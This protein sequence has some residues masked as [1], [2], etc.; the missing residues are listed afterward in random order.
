MPNRS[1]R[2]L[3]ILSLILLSLFAFPPRLCAHEEIA[4]LSIQK[5]GFFKFRRSIFKQRGFGF[6]KHA[7]SPPP[8]LYV[9]PQVASLQSNDRIAIAGDS[10]TYLGFQPGGWVSLWQQYVQTYYP[11]MNLQF[12]DY[13]VPSDHSADLLARFPAILQS[14][15]TVVIIYIGLN[16]GG[17]GTSYLPQQSANIQ[18]MIDQCRAT[19]SVRMVVLVSPFCYGEQY[20]GQNP[21]DS[22]LNAM[23]AS[24]ASLAAQN[25]CPF[26]NLRSLWNS[27]EYV[28]NHSDASYGILCDPPGVH[29]NALGAQIISGAMIK[30]FGE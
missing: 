4:P 10:V 14:N 7:P 27:A 26:I 19:S 18:A 22:V 29:P 1:S 3:W 5:L 25:N 11:W 17:Y 8:Q 9:P 24:Q 16:D 12:L 15:P 6:N 20:D 21:Y 2:S 30:S 13:G 28:Y 23:L